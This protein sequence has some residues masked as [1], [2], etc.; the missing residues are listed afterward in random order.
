M[1]PQP[2]GIS[3]PDDTDGSL[4]LAA[5]RGLFLDL[6]QMHLIEELSNF[7]LPALE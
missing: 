7:Y 3:G 6:F 1:G 4:W 2:H 5:E